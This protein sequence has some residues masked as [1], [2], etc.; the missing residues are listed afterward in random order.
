MNRY[1]ETL[2][3]NIHLIYQPK[4]YVT[5]RNEVRFVHPLQP[6]LTLVQCYEIEE[7]YLVDTSNIAKIKTREIIENFANKKL[8]YTWEMKMNLT[9][10]RIHHH[11]YMKIIRIQMNDLQKPQFLSYF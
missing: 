8:G 2:R 11:E 4:L 10:I 3:I 1:I 7:I 6:T 9:F 5:A